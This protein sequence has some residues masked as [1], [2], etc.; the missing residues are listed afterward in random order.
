MLKKK[1]GGREEVSRSMRSRRLETHEFIF[2]EETPPSRGHPRIQ[3]TPPP[4]NSDQLLIK[5][6]NHVSV[7]D[8]L[9]VNL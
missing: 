8:C 6:F 3:S 2:G 9:R 7:C 5:Q 1:E 4:H